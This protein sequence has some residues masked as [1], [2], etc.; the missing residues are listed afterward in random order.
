MFVQRRTRNLFEAVFTT[1]AL[2]YHQTVHNLRQGHSNALMSI[3]MT[4][5]QSLVMIVGFLAMYWIFGVRRSPIRGDF[6]MFIMSGIFMFMAFNQAMGKVAGAGNS[7][8]A[9]LKHGPMNTA[10]AMS[11]AALSA[12]YTNVLSATLIYGLYHN[13]MNPE[14]I[15]NIPATLGMLIFSWFSG[16]SLGLIFLS[17]NTW[18]PTAGKII[19]QL[20]RRVNMIASG[21]MFVANT[22]PTFLL[23][24]FDWNPLFHIIDQTRGF[25]FINY[26]PRN[27][28]LE[29]PFYFTLA[30]LMIGLM[31]EF[32]TRN[33]V[34][35]SWSA[36]R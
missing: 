19:T 6:L 7:Q 17:I 23:S 20:A 9:M 29:Y 13:F 32:V 2:I 11:G 8:S 3:A 15:E 21:K 12:L 26:V 36:G 5:L 24:M 35:L 33:S 4:V 28:N 16:C 31:A 14:P 30:M 10:I 34:S 27:S 1:G 22:M 25:V 18:F